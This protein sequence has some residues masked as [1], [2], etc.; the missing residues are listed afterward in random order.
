LIDRLGLDEDRAEG[1]ISSLEGLLGLEEEAAG[2]TLVHDAGSRMLIIF[3]PGTGAKRTARIGVETG[4]G[5]PSPQVRAL[6]TGQMP[7]THLGIHETANVDFIR[8][9]SFRAE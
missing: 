6:K 4:S 1:L 8:V 3:W 2:V 9:E 5:R 7:G